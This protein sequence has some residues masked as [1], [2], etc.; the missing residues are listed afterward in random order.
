MRFMAVRYTALLKPSR[1]KTVFSRPHQPTQLRPIDDGTD[2]V[3]SAGME[4]HPGKTLAQFM[5]E[6]GLS[7]EQVAEGINVLPRSVYRYLHGRVPKP[8][9]M[10]R[11][12][13]F[14]NGEVTA[15]SFLRYGE[16]LA[17]AS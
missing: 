4:K 11:I 10:A 17:I 7:A 1:A 12:I 14:T 15:D 16:D 13:R 3:N 6:R 8:R 5:Q 9:V 2:L